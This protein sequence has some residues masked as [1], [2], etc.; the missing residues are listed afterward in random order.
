MK[1]QEK[2]EL[3]TKTQTELIKM[4]DDTKKELVMLRLDKAQNK[5]KNTRQIFNLRKKIA[6]FLSVLKAKELA[7]NV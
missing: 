4:L 6:V 7:K 3:H 5:L 1:T 2:K